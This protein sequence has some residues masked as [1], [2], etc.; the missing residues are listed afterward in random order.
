MVEGNPQRPPHRHQQLGVRPGR[1]APPDLRRGLP[2]LPVPVLPVPLLGDG[3][4]EQPHQPAAGLPA[5]PALPPDHGLR[6]VQPLRPGP[7]PPLLQAGV[8]DARGPA[9]RRGARPPRRVP[10]LVLRP[11][12]HPAGL[13]RALG[14]RAGLPCVCG[15][16]PC[17]DHDFP[18][19][20]ALLGG[21]AG[22]LHGF[23]A[24]PADDF[25][26]CGLPEGAGLV[27]RGAAV[28]GGPPPVPPHP[29][30]APARSPRYDRGADL[31][32]PQAH[33]PLGH[34]HRVRVRGPPHPAEDRPQ[35][36]PLPQGPV[37]D[38]RL[39]PRVRLGVGPRVIPASRSCSQ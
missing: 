7:A 3:V 16:P 20:H 6:P 38:E 22:G 11:G 26:G 13:E 32:A 19:P 28:P 35:D 37:H 10:G 33:L 30:P 36:P 31:Q 27:P 29:P 12:G 17:A 5:A 4:Q 34:L 1:P 14:V 2:V 23:C 15:D 8:R 18:F 25:A 9:P 39:G 24:P 21:P